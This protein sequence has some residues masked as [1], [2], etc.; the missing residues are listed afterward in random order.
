MIKKNKIIY[1]SHS[2]IRFDSRILKEMQSAHDSGNLVQGIGIN[3]RG[4]FKKAT[5]I[6]HLL[7]SSIS[8]TSRKLVFLP[9]SIRHLFSM[10]ELTTKM[11]F[12][13]VRSKPDLIH[14]N[15]TVV[16]PKGPELPFVLGLDLQGGTQLTYEA[17]VSKIPEAE[18]SSS[19]EG[20]RDIIERRVN[21]TGVAEPIIQVNRSMAGDYRVIV[22]LAGVK[23]L[24]MRLE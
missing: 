15:D 21:S 1:L 11:V 10:C 9:K 17:D 23:K 4:K 8:F 5:E 3:S 18:R 16:L 24:M 22:E 19:L 14:C 7:I 13:T 2:D 12:F 6:E 20:I